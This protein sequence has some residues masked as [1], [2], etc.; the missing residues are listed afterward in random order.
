MKRT[1]VVLLALGVACSAIPVASTTPVSQSLAQETAEYPPGLSPEGVTDPLALVDAHRGTLENT[2]YTLATTATYRR[3]N[4]SLLA[5]RTGTTRV[6]PG[7]SSYHVV[8]S[9][10][11]R[12]GTRPLG[13]GTYQIALWANETD[14]VVANYPADDG[15]TYQRYARQRAPFDPTTQWELLYGAFGATN[16][17]VVERFERGGTTLFRVVSTE[18]PGARSA[19]PQD[20]RFGFVAV[21][22]SR[23]VV[24]T[25]QQTDRTTFDDRPAV[26]SRTFHVTRVGNTTVERPD[27]FGQ[28]VANGSTSR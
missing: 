12:N 27:W 11:Q 4:G 8:S 22:D 6:A 23:G 28:A 25:F 16:T 15:P 26:V 17:T 21:V 2:S 3:P 5:R 24:R 1:I 10:T 14:A 7:A 9:Q 20:G 19:Y 13:V 18:Q